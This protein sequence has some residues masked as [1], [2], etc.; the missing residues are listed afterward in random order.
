MAHY[1][2]EKQTNKLRLRKISAVLR[3]KRFEF[4]AGSGVFSKSK[5]DKGTELLAN[6][7]QTKNNS[8][9]LDMGCGIGVIGIVAASIYKANVLMADINERALELAKLNTKLNNVNADIRK[10]NLYENIK[11]KFDAI[12]V[13]PPMKA[14]K[15]I[16]HEIIEKAI[17]HIKE[18]GTLQLVARHNKGG[19]DLS[20]KMKDVFGN[21]KIISRKG[22]YR[23]YMAVKE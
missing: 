12:I 23:V 16:C 18:K 21:V 20:N 5:V 22:G 4:N 9:I 14:G 13:N 7:M 2:S 17:E 19:R 15:K 3:G 11:E 1:F 6:S 10:S 8:D